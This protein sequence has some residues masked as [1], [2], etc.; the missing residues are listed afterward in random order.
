MPEKN[1][2]HHYYSEE[3]DERAAF[4]VTKRHIIAYLAVECLPLI[5]CGLAGIVEKTPVCLNGT[6]PQC[7][8][9]VFACKMA[10]FHDNIIRIPLGYILISN[11]SGIYDKLCHEGELTKTI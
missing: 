10:V 2:P 6:Y 8:R 4:V 1:V 11:V 5:L 9:A 7:K 3:K